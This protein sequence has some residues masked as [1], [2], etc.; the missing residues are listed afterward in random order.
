M[1]KPLS[2]R[3]DRIANAP[4]IETNP[5]Y[6]ETLLEAAALAR[7][8]EGAEVGIVSCIGGDPRDFLSVEIGR[9]DTSA[10]KHRQRVALVPVE[11]GA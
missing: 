3:L 8:V 5:A 7:R 4:G 11:G 6:T 2:E 10:L 1:T 9:A